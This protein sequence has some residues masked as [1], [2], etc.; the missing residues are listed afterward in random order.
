MVI[1]MKTVKDSAITGFWLGAVSLAVSWLL[2]FLKAPTVNLTFS[3][4]DINVRQQLVQGVD[5]SI[6]GKV[7]NLISGLIPLGWQGVVSLF[8]TAFL[9]VLIGTIAFN[10]ITI[11][12][13]NREAWRFALIM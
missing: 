6:G 12:R 13:P 7:I 11:F 9:I 8:V 3:A 4:V 10:Y 5:T 2:N 1:N